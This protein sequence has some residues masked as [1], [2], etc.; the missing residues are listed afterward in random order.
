V[1][2]KKTK[3][4]KAANGKTKIRDEEQVQILTLE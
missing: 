1:K 4:K 2:R 3:E